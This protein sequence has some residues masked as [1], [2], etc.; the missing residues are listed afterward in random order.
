LIFPSHEAHAVWHFWKHARSHLNS[1]ATV[2]V[3]WRRV[4]SCGDGGLGWAGRGGGEEGGGAFSMQEEEEVGCWGPRQ[5]ARVDGGS[6]ARKRARRAGGVDRRPWVR[7]RGPMR[8]RRRRRRRRQRWRGRRRRRRWGRR[9]R[10]WWG[11]WRGAAPP[12]QK[13][14]VAAR[15][16][17]KPCPNCRRWGRRRRRR[18]MVTVDLLPPTPPIAAGVEAVVGADGRRRRWG[19]RRRRWGRRWELRCGLRR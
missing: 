7:P 8:R 11:R 12:P 13:S 6:G 14:F 19:R 1:K 9:R 17:A 15:L 4:G 10:R 16:Q 3:G 5:W 18:P 2:L